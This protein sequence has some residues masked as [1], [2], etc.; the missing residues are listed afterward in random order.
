MISKSELEV[1]NRCIL[2]VKSER[3]WSNHLVRKLSLAYEVDLIEAVSRIRKYGYDG[4]IREIDSLAHRKN[5]Q[6]LFCSIDFFYS[7]GFEFIEKISSP[8]RKVLITFDD[9]TLHEF[10]EITALSCDLVLTADPISVLRYRE[11]GIAAEYFP[12]ESS[13][14]LYRD[15]QLPKTM[16][17]LFFGNPSL[18]DRSQ[19]LRYL[20]QRGIQVAVVG[21]E[22]EFLSNEDLVRKICEAKLVVNFS[23]TGVLEKDS[24]QNSVYKQYFQLKGRIIESGLCG[25]PCIS[26]YSPGGALLFTEQEVPT[27]R[28]QAECYQLI[29]DLLANDFERTLI[30]QSLLRKIVLEYEDQPIMRRVGNALQRFERTG[31]NT[32][33]IQDV[34]K[35]P[36][37]YYR[38]MLRSR[39][40]ILDRKYKDQLIEIAK[41]IVSDYLSIFIKLLLVGDV[42]LWIAYRNIKTAKK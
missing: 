12:L 30:G 11:K 34:R 14:L 25:T 6:V 19:Y 39:I 24:I 16:D 26:E 15:L 32:S 20:S 29:T 1:K 13:R 7:L 2:L 35:I 23:K 5:I 27:F 33:R 3:R 36:Y 31:M 9:I 28:D 21:G 40:Q 22:R 18:A 38:R 41:I 8:I 10:N 17:V 37:W 4:L 42:I